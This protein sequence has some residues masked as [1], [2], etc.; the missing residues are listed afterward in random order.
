[1]VRVCAVSVLPS[2]PTAQTR[3]LPSAA[4]PVSHCDR[5]SGDGLVTSCTGGRSSAR[6]GAMSWLASLLRPVPTAQASAAE[7]VTT[8]AR[9]LAEPGVT[10]KLGVGATAQRWPFQSRASVRPSTPSEFRV[11]PT[12]QTSAGPGAETPARLALA[13]GTLGGQPGVGHLGSPVLD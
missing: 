4:T 5:L 6:S 13:P 7:M 12:A 11:W 2:M 1:M 9:P 8:E 3:A 10:E